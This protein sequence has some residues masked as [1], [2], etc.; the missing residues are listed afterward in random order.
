MNGD[1]DSFLA[2]KSVVYL[3]TPPLIYF[4]EEDPTYLSPVKKIISK[5]D[6]GEVQGVSS[7]LTLIEVLV[8]PIKNEATDIVAQ[9]KEALLEGQIKLHPIGEEIAKKAAEIRAK[10]GFRTPDAIQVSTAIHV[11]AEVFV[12]NDAQLRRVTEIKVLYLG[13]FVDAPLN[14]KP[15]SN[16]LLAWFANFLK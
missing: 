10:Y 8:K 3:D 14:A 5:I 15:Q 7:F 11:G 16:G 13:D 4:F 12:T 6:S 1:I 9:Y 2:G